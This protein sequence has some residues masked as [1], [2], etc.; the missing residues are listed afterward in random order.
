MSALSETLAGLSA[1]KKALASSSSDTAGLMEEVFFSGANPGGLRMLSYTPENLPAKS[2]LVVVLHG[3]TQSGAGYASAAGWLT[4]ADRLGFAVLAPEQT[5]NNNPNRCFNWFEPEDTQRGKGEAAS[6]H[7]M[8][9]YMIVSRDLDAERVF[10]T[11]LSAGG[12]MTAAMLAAYPET[13]AA[14]AVIAGLPAGAA[15][16]VHRAFAVMRAGTEAPMLNLRLAF[17]APARLALFT[18][19]SPFG[20]APRT[21]LF[22]TPTRMI[23]SVNGQ[24]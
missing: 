23:C 8:I 13:F 17:D 3:C 12:A 2:P 22:Q 24:V 1:I 5:S 16:S 10:I 18:R 4:L 9:T 21:T 19:G 11:G 7:A 6:I 14:G 15:D 20:T